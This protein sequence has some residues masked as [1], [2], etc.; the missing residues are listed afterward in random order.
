MKI[1]KYKYPKSSFLSV[2]KDLSLITDKIMENERL[3]RLL[4]YTSKD[5]L[6]QP[7]L[8]EDQKIEL[9]G[10]NI[11]V[12]PKLY[13]DGTV[14]NYIII[15]FDNFVPSG[16]SEFR[17]NV[18]EFDIICHFDQWQLNDLSLRPYKI[19]AE[20]DSMFNDQKLTGIGLLQFLSGSQIVLNDEFAGFCLM[21]EAVHGGEDEKNALNPVEQ[22]SIVNNFN[23]MYNQ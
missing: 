10:K 9:F 13:V 4:Y 1:E 12:V 3:Q 11:K 17:D 15:S 6:Q 19:A 21:Y 18:I 14:L 16:N 23:K 20:I 5:A 22:E 8:T 7:K 2:D